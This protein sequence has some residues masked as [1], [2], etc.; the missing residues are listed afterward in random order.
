[1]SEPLIDPDCRDPHKHSTCAGGPCQC[2]CHMSDDTGDRLII[3]AD[4]VKRHGT[5]AMRECPSCRSKLDAATGVGTDE[6]PDP[7]D[8]SIC[9]YCAGPLIFTEDG[10]RRPT[11]VEHDEMLRSPMYRK[12]IAVVNRILRGAS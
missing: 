11:L 2:P 7:G 4:I 10:Y 1:M 8:W 9:V 12:A 5:G 6:A 3:A